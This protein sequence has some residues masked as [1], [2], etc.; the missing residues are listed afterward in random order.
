LKRIWLGYAYL[1]AVVWTCSTLFH[2]RD[3]WLTECM[4]YL[5]ACA[6]VFYAFFVAISFT[7]PW[8]Q[9]NPFGRICWATFGTG[10]G[11]FYAHHVYSFIENINYGHN[12]FYCILCS[13]AT[14]SIYLLWMTCE[15]FY[16]RKRRSLAILAGTIT[17]GLIGACFEVMDF[18]PIF[19]T[20]DAHSL[21][22]AITIPTPWLL[23]EFAVEEYE[24]ELK[25]EK[26]RRKVA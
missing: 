26:Q 16:A 6:V 7:V 1:G 8:L 11:L 20:F 5:A 10:L 13:I 15:C 4:D 21:F 23:A 19:W 22:H 25:D 17:L 12:M 3:F 14:A 18:P 24:Y 2:A 9:R